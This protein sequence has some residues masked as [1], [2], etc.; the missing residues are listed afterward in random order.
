MEPISVLSTTPIYIATLGLI[1][2]PITVRIALYRIKSRIS[3][4]SADD[5]EM[6]RRMRGQA[7]FVETVP[8]ALFL[9]VTMEMLGASNAELHALGLMLVLGRVAHY[10]GIIENA[11]LT[12]RI[13]GIAAT[14]LTIFLGSIWISID[15]LFPNVWTAL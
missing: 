8:I 12:F 11:P 15:V 5:P 7:N 4:G 6:L 1:F 13:A 10:F 3:L 9:L 14:L 2:L